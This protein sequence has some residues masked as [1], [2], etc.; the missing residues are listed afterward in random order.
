MSTLRI[1]V[2]CR[3]ASGAADLPVFEVAASADEIAEG[4]HYDR[5]RELAEQC[6]Y[7]GP[8]L[9][10][11][12]DE[13]VAIVC[14]AQTL[15]L[16]PQVVVVDLSGGLVNS[17]RCDAGAIKVVCFDEDDIDE[18]SEAVAERP[19]GENG[20]SVRCWAHVQAAEV[21]PGLKNVRR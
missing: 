2:A 3:N 1:A 13:Q 19:V 4:V 16:I 9:C 5:A 11:D 6:G 14:A 15:D 18:A 17:V 7:E 8:L 20:E 10:F 12:P 21:D